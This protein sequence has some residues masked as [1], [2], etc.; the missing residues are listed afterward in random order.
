MQDPS[1]WGRIRFEY[2]I[3]HLLLGVPRV[4]VE[5]APAFVRGGEPQEC[6]S[7]TY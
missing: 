6:G 7:G 5:A 2:E 4:T 1:Q 3:K